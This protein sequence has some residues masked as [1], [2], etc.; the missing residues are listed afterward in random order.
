MPCWNADQRV[1]D[2]LDA[3]PD[4][5]VTMVTDADAR[6][7][8]LAAGA[9]ALWCWSITPAEAAACPGLG[10]ISTPAAGADYLPVAQLTAD[11]CTVSVSHGHHGP[12]MAEHA[13]GM[14]LMLARRLELAPAHLPAG[15]WQRDDYRHGVIDLLGSRLVIA[16]YGAIGQAIAARAQ[17]FGLAVVG[18][19]RQARPADALGV[20]TLGPADHDHALAGADILVNCLPG[21]PSTSQWLTGER[22]DRLADPAIVIN[23]GRGSTVDEAALR[24]RLTSGRI[25]AGLD[26]TATEPLPVDDPLRAC[27]NL[28]ITPHVSAVT[29]AYL[30]RAAGYQREQMQ[31]YLAGEALRSVVSGGESEGQ[32]L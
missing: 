12:A 32:V 30:V 13:L 31:R 9:D 26:V 17:A 14:I 20:S 2:A 6:S 29:D 27:P 22:L 5:R 8:L 19:A 24:A 1:I 11:G 25:R 28:L 3:G 18:L 10:W 23:L 7:D 21:N 15:H 16:G 4:W